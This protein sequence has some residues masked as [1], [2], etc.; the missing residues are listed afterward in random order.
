MVAPIRAVLQPLVA[1]LG[2]LEPVRL[3]VGD[4]LAMD[5]VVARLLAAG[6]SRADLVERRGQF[7]VRGGIL[8]VFPP[9]E[10]HP[11]RVEFW[12]DEV[13]EIRFFKVADQRSLHVAP[14]AWAPPCRELLLTESVRQRAAELTEAMPA[15]REML[16]ALAAGIPAEGMESL[17]PV[18]VDR[19]SLLLD[20][21]PAG[22]QVL[23][24]DPERVRTR[25]SE[26]VRTSD[27]FL[28]ASWSSA[29]SGGQVPV[30]LR[31]GSFLSLGQARTHA[32]ETGLPWWTL[33]PFGADGELL[34]GEESIRTT[35]ARAVAPYRGDAA[36]AIAD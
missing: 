18:L 22:A 16:D 6:Y 4:R 36:R 14:G 12:G 24:C 19:M 7:A 13:E 35:G 30:D 21:L 26:L 31:A 33:T 9:T 1:G 20:E 5:E 23:L 17:A 8:D 15:M 29:A 34:A 2:D 10:D 28:A 25:A 11:L 3:G 32:L 27:E